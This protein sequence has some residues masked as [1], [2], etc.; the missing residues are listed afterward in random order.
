MQ[1]KT[2]KNLILVIIL[3]IVNLIN[4]TTLSYGYVSPNTYK[5]Q[6]P[7]SLVID[8]ENESEV[9]GPIKSIE[10]QVVMLILNIVILAIIYFIPTVISI[11]K[12]HTYKLYIICI[13]I[14]LGWTLIGW[15]VCLIW[16]LIDNK[17]N[18]ADIL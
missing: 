7:S 13:N 2:I 15:L 12:K 4:W 10:K 14:I 5:P 16:S 8:T 17:K 9:I 3:I 1:R 6:Q 11:I 18:R